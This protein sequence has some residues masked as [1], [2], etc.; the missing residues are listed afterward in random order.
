MFTMVPTRADQATLLSGAIDEDESL[1]PRLVEDKE[2]DCMSLM[3]KVLEVNE[4]SILDA[5]EAFRATG[6]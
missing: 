4:L 6:G 5:V 3:S 2:E 1:M